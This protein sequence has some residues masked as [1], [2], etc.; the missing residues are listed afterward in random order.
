MKYLNNFLLLTALLFLY[1]QAEA[2]KIRSEDNSLNSGKVQWLPQQISA[3]DVPFGKPVSFDFEVKNVSSENLMLLQ[4]RSSCF[5]TSAEFSKQPVAPGQS[6]IIKVTY[7][8][9]REGDFY[10]IVTV[11]TNTLFSYHELV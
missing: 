6:T 9:A 4:V 11:L 7:D 1:Q 5:C 2:Q 10:R 3:G 8:G